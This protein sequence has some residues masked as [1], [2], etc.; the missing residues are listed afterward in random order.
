MRR[1][2]STPTLYFTLCA[3]VLAACTR[4][5]PEKAAATP[6]VL[7][8][9]DRVEIFDEVWRTINEHY[10]DPN[11]RGVDW[12]AVGER[13]RPQAES[14]QTDAEFYGV[15]E[16]ML[17]ELRDGHTVFEQPAPPG[18]AGE[19]GPRGSVGVKLGDAEGRVVA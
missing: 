3:L 4:P 9:Q 1:L 13:Y 8:P 5:A 14:A 16:Q 12:R 15:F 11:F 7:S 17:A 2:L 19:G 6:N 18:A 10:Y